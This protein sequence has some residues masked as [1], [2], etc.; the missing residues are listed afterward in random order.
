[1]TE[2]RPFSGA[3]DVF[4][5]AD[6]IWRRLA[7]PDW[8]EAFRAHPRIGESVSAP[9]GSATSDWSRQEQA[10]ASRADAATRE[11]LAAGN[12]EYERRF[13]YIFIV[14]ATG[15][16]AGEMLTMLQAR[17]PNDPAVELQT[18]AE[19]QRKITRLRLEKLLSAP[20]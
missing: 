10:G 4:S 15:R 12:A 1:M 13:G 8:L 7:P 6:D 5:R 2:A 3:A 17:L 18:A 20:A 11:A 19:E 14:C 9:D 16:S